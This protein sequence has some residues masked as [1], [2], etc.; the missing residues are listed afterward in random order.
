M[1]L[2]VHDVMTTEVVTITPDTDFKT[3][4]TLLERHRINLLPVLEQE[5]RVAGTV[6]EADLLAKAEWQGRKP[7]GRFERW[8]VRERTHENAV[9][10]L[11]VVETEDR[12]VGIV[13]RH[14][15]LKVFPSN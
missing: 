14:E 3:I 9:K 7:P 2:K 1:T 10:R 11:P 6:S 5:R 15:V 8:L 4:A 13:T 12:L